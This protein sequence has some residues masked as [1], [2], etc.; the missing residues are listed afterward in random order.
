MSPDNL[1][2]LIGWC[3]MLGGVVSG[4]IIGLFFHQEK[5]AGGYGSFQR[6]LMR[7]SQSA[8]RADAEVRIGDRSLPDHCVVWV[9]SRYDCNAAL[10]LFDCLEEAVSAF[11]PHTRD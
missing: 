5:W 10:L 4:A 9:C 6:R 11:V 7:F 3:A 2:I 1:H 8:V